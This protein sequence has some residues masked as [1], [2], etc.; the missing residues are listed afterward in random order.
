MR[1]STPFSRRTE[2]RG[3]WSREHY[4]VLLAITG[5]RERM[6]HHA[7]TYDP[8]RV[9][10][11]E[12]R[13]GDLHRAKNAHYA[14]WVRTNGG[15]LRPGVKRLLAE[16]VAADLRLAVATTTSRANLDALLL[17]AFPEG[18]PFEVLICGEDVRAKKP[19]PEVYV[20]A[21]LALNLPPAACIAFEDTHN[22]VRA[23]RRAGLRVV[24]TPSVYSA[25][26]DFSDATL[27][28][29][30]LDAGSVTVE[31]LTKLAR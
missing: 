31:M 7:K 21:L 14:G 27:V 10:D 3:D 5:G 2:F 13:V 6:L 28:A 25:G 30:D 23:A 26:E 11:I 20:K 1:R 24:A 8:Q 9:A 29:N 17:A 22:G 16:A 4:R 19:D 15:A 12:G 18:S